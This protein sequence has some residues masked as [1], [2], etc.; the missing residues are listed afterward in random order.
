MDDL[1]SVHTSEQPIA[2]LGGGNPASIAEMERIFRDE[3]KRLTNKGRDIDTLFGKYDA[4]QGNLQFIDSLAELLNDQ[5][6]WPVTRNNVALTNGSQ[7]SFGI[8]FNLF[9]GQFDDGVFRK[10]LLPLAPEYIGYSDVGL[11]S[12]QRFNSIKPKISF[13]DSNPLYFKYHVDFE[14][15]N[16][17]DQ[18][19]AVCVSRPTNPTGNVIS[20]AEIAVL[21]QHCR[22]HNIPFIIDGAYGLPFPGILFGEATPIWDKN[23]ILCLSLSKLGLP[24]L[25]TGIVIADESVIEVIKNSN[26]ILSLAPGGFGAGLV[27]RLVRE[28]QLLDLCK[29]LIQPY[30]QQKCQFAVQTIQNAM[31]GIPVRIHR[32]EGAIFLWLW[33]DALSITSQELYERLKLRGVY[34]IPGHHFFPG[35][36]H[37]W[38]HKYQCIRVSY[39][40][41]S[42]MIRRGVKIIADELRMAYD[43]QS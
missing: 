1:G 23:T 32:P 12:K 21:Q 4:P 15:L 3:L 5:F 26:A 20:D 42:E 33:F 38:D 19:A 24:G 17:T 40:G 11:G 8:L 13:D 10:I 25:R 29:T 41:D 34:I 6:G 22:K 9:S 43:Q 37:D 39:A 30:Y 27:T 31:S 36:D 18:Y 35:M 28:H 2:M 14:A 7:S 16:I